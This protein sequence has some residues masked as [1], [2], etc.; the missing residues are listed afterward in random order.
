MLHFFPAT[1]PAFAYA[2]SLLKCPSPLHFYCG[3]AQLL[4]PLPCLSRGWHFPALAMPR[5]NASF[6]G[7]G[8]VL[9]R[10]GYSWTSTWTSIIYIQEKV[11]VKEALTLHGYKVN[12][13]KTSSDLWYLDNFWRKC[14]KAEHISVRWMLSELPTTEKARRALGSED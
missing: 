6:R 13:S 8:H 10:E 11:F 12:H 14:V 2:V 5:P 3:S 7:A 9:S 4:P 1:P